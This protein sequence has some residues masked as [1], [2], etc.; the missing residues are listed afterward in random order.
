[1]IASQPPPVRGSSFRRV[2]GSPEF[3]NAGC[4]RI[5]VQWVV[6]ADTAT[7][8]VGQSATRGKRENP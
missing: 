7:R 1:M 5:V 8:D 3:R 2:R 6:A 4:L